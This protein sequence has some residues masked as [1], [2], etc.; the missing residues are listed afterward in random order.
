MTPKAFDLTPPAFNPS[1]PKAAEN[2]AR[3]EAAATRLSDVVTAK[4]RFA[5]ELMTELLSGVQSA[6]RATKV[7]TLASR[8]RLAVKDHCRGMYPD[9][10]REFTENLD[11]L[12]EQWIDLC[13][14]HDA[15]GEELVR[16]MSGREPAG[17]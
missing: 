14:R 3:A 12:A 6:D 9:E 1:N 10:S 8:L 5:D 2:V 16:A 13:E 4:Q 11:A 7:E 15:A 17:A